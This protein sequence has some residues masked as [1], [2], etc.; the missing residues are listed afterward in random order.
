MR[1]LRILSGPFR[2][3]PIVVDWRGG[4]RKWLGIYEREVSFWWSERVASTDLFYD[5]GAS[6]GYFTCG[7]AY[8]MRCNSRVYA[9]DPGLAST[10]LVRAISHKAFS[11]VK[12]TLLDRS[13]GNTNSKTTDTLDSF[14]ED[15]ADNAIVKVDVEGAELDVLAGATRFLENDR[16][17]WNVEIH[18]QHRLDLVENVF[19][20]YGKE[21]RVIYP[22]PHFFFGSE[23]RPEWTAWLVTI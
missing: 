10:G 11:Q 16:I 4:K 15:P 1:R 17:H 14:Y 8:H 13:I 21:F 19:K 2:G 7:V 20:S 3:T 22:Q 23:L 5:V 6:D 18:G 12:F 9:F